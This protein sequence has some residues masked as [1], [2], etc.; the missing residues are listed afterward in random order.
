MKDQLKVVLQHIYPH[1]P[2]SRLVHWLTRRHCGPL[3]RLVMRRF[4]HHFGIDMRDYQQSNPDHYPTFNAFFT[5]PLA[6][7]ARPL[8]DDPAAVLSPVDGV[9]SEFGRI[10]DGRLIQAKGIDYG[11]AELL[12]CNERDAERYRDGEFIT[13]YLSP[14]DYHRIHAPLNARVTTMTHIPGALFSVNP[15]TTRRLPRLFARNERVAVDLQGEGESGTTDHVLVMVGAIFVGSIETVWAGEVTP[16]AGQQIT[17]RNYL[18]EKPNQEKPIHLLR[19]QELG[20]FNMGSTVILLFPRG[21]IDWLPAIASGARVRMGEAIAT[22]QLPAV[23]PE[24]PPS[25]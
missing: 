12:G 17:S 7:G 23:K 22:L 5:R 1:H 2:L 9:V 8:A 19:G 3:C 20:R 25:P 18:A 21:S 24:S 6:T 11:V 4:I 10:V 15:A 13:I 14:R 16:P